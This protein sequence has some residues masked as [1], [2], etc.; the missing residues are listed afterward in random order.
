MRIICDIKMIYR[1][2]L[3]MIRGSNNIVEGHSYQ[4]T[5][6]PTEDDMTEVLTC[7]VCGHESKADWS[8]WNIND[9]YNK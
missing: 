6:Y 9:Y 1:T 3:L 4:I 2:L 8:G 5:K 7:N